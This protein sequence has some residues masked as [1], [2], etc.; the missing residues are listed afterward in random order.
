[1]KQIVQ[2]KQHKIGEL[3][4]KMGELGKQLYQARNILHEQKQQRKEAIVVGVFFCQ[5][6]NFTY[7]LSKVLLYEDF[8]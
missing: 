4:K 3:T 6:L 8:R 7:S 5:N 2:T 1:L